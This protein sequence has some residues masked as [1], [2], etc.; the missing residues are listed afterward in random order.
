MPGIW[1]RGCVS[2]CL[3][4]DFTLRV[5]SSLLE[6][7]KVCCSQ[8]KASFLVL[9]PETWPQKF[10]LVIYF[11]VFLYICSVPFSKVVYIH[12]H[13]HTQLLVH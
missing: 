13:T 3:L 8:S 9:F 11:F 4:F 7:E 6:G 12:T 2:Q 1:D 5:L 10:A